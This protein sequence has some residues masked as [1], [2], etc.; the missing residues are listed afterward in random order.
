M[1][2]SISQLFTQN[3]C[4]E[5]AE[6]GK[7]NNEKGFYLCLA[8]AVLVMVVFAPSI[9]DKLGISGLYLPLFYVD[10]VAASLQVALLAV[11]V[12]AVVSM[13]TVCARR[14]VLSI[15]TRLNFWLGRTAYPRWLTYHPPR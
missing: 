11:V 5:E 14:L 4:K 7:K 2:K 6:K 15:D 13:S 3:S 9:F 1:R 8:L 10:A 12:V